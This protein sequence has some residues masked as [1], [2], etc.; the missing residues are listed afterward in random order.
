MKKS[1]WFFF[2]FFYVGTQGEG[3][4]AKKQAYRFYATTEDGERVTRTRYPPPCFLGHR[5]FNGLVKKR[6]SVRCWH[7][8]AKR[9]N[10]GGRVL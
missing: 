3:N 4:S 9:E 6:L 10:Y 1:D 7:R 2:F 5:A 8:A